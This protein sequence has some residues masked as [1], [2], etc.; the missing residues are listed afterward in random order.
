[1]ELATESMTQNK[2]FYQQ[3]VWALPLALLL[4]AG[5]TYALNKFVLCKYDGNHSLFFIAFKYWAPLLC[6]IAVIA[7]IYRLIGL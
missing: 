4:A 7:F 3:S 5:I 6:I 2:K 1:M